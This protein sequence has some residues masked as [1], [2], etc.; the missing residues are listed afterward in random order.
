MAYEAKNNTGSLFK[1]DKKE[2]DTHPDRNGQ[3][4]I[5]G[6][7]YWV[8]GWIKQDRNGNPWMSLSFKAKDAPRSAAGEY[9]NER[10][11][12]AKQAAEIERGQKRVPGSAKTPIDLDDEVP[13]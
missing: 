5:D 10:R 12:D 1:N 7:A 4:M 8:S 9:E 13:F 11:Q 3:C 6:K 2:K